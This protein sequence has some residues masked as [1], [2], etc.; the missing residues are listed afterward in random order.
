VLIQMR[1]SAYIGLVS[2]EPG[3]ADE[4]V[5]GNC[6]FHGPRGRYVEKAFT[7][8]WVEPLS[9]FM[10]ALRASTNGFSRQQQYGC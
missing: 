4:N 1:Q 7:C 10:S 2:G 5:R 9:Y 6:K 3:V 8:L